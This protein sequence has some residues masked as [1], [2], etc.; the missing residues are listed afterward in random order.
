MEL[1]I[2]RF[3]AVEEKKRVDEERQISEKRDI[4]RTII[5]ERL[6]CYAEDIGEI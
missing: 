1:L 4:K 5:L 6:F 3:W 2:M